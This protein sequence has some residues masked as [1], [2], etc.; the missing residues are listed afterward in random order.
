MLSSQNHYRKG[1]FVSLYFIVLISQKYSPQHFFW[2]HSARSQNLHLY[3]PCMANLLHFFLYL[4]LLTK[5]KPGGSVI[6]CYLLSICNTCRNCLFFF[7]FWKKKIF[8]LYFLSYQKLF[9]N[10]TDARVI[11]PGKRPVGIFTETHFISPQKVLHPE[12]AILS[13]QLAK[14]C[15]PNFPDVSLFPSS[16]CHGISL[17]FAVFIN[18]NDEHSSQASEPWIMAYYFCYLV[19]HLL[20][21]SLL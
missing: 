8:V 17:H 9:L 18:W 13:H 5:M 4:E 21:I 7:F 11:W 16:A 6:L 12:K 19:F 15:D 20:R 10:N 1:D 3:F 14:P 2:S